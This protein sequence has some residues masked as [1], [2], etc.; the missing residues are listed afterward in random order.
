MAS[1]ARW[2]VPIRLSGQLALLV[3]AEGTIGVV[4]E[5]RRYVWTAVS[6]CWKWS[7]EVRVIATRLRSP[8]RA[9][10]GGRRSHTRAKCMTVLVSFG[11]AIPV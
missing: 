7:S 10:D 8:E 5:I 2:R 3:S 11:A 1:I 9:Q 6:W 4:M